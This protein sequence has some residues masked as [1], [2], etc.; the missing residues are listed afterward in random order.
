MCLYN[1]REYAAS[2]KA[3]AAARKTPRS[4]RTADEWIRI[5][6]IDMRRDAEIEYAEGEAQRQ[7]KSL[8]ERRAPTQYGAG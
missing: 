4:T 7:L 5:I 2:I 6:G 8:T 3:F 1:E